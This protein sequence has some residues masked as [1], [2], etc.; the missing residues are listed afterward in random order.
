[1]STACPDEDEIVAYAQGHVGAAQ[2][3]RIAAHVERCAACEGLVA[4]A[5]RATTSLRQAD[6]APMPTRGSAL[7]RYLVLDQLGSGGLGR[8]VA[9]YDPELDRRVAIKLLER[10][11]SSDDELRLVREA[12]ALAK[13]KHP[14]VVAVHDVGVVDDRVFIAMELVDG[15]TLREWLLAKERGWEEIREVFL[16][17]ARGLA[18]VHDAGL[19]HR[20]VKPGNILVGHDGR[21]Q[22]A[23]FG[24]ARALDRED[25]LAPRADD[26]RRSSQLDVPLTA[27]GTVMGTPAYMPPEQHRGQKVDARADQFGLGVALFE[28]LHGTRPFAGSTSEQLLASASAGL[29]VE[30]QA[31][32]VPS[33]LRRVALRALAADPKDRYPS[34]H[35]LALALQQ[36]RRRRRTRIVAAAAALVIGGAAAWALVIAPALALTVETRDAIEALVIEARAAAAQTNF[37]HPPADAPTQPTAYTKVLEL[38]ARGE[39]LADARA[40][41]LRDEFAGT[42]VRLGDRFWEVEGGTP[43]AAEFYAAALVFDDAHPRALSRVGVSVAALV[44]LRE[45]AAGLS[46][47]EPELIAV[48][49]VLAMAKDDE[50]V[51]TQEI[52][53]AYARKVEPP[54][55]ITAAIETVLGAP[56]RDAVARGRARVSK[57]EPT[58]VASKPSPSAGASTSASTTANDERVVASSKPRAAE[59]P[60]REGARAHVGEGRALLRKG[61]LAAA[62]AAFH[63]ALAIDRNDVRALA[64]LGEVAFQQRS[65]ESSAKFLER[66]VALAPKN[67]ELHLD[68]GDVYFKVLRYSDAR[69]QY[70]E[71]RALGHDGAARRLQRLDDR[72]GGG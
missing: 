66:A 71:A 19:V 46:F 54:P 38:E 8:V 63:R 55:A 14:N 69:A 65:Y 28:A 59:P 23:D 48:A 50:G 43:F 47:G 1:M 68:L 32:R 24:L 42:L 3:E 25:E 18:A 22:V 41:E 20:D 37:V 11:H 29:V 67:A 39:S 15:T 12:Q 36:D 5:A 27:I 61:E 21:V 51:R 70:D 52:E 2:R 33:W 9:A 62:E 13:L 40:G 56:G 72:L 31:R 16:A 26:V 30:V 10:R 7:G 58:L 45:R 17:V 49:P 53:A 34:M 64:G 6:D 60:D 57:P 44:A 35:E 4:E